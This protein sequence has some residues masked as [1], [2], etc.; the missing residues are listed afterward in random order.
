MLSSVRS[1]NLVDIVST[2]PTLFRRLHWLRA[3]QCISFKLAVMIY[4]CVRGLGSAYLADA[5]RPVARIPGRQRLRYVP[6]T[7]LSTVG[8]RAFPVAAARTRNS[9]PAEVTSS[10]SPP[11][12]KT[13]LKSHLFSASFP[14]FPKR[15]SICKVSEVHASAFFSL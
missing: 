10:N 3:P 15:C 7:R 9:F 6:S 13:K 4:Q 1:Q 8:N 5:L 14:Q 2:G 11:T 12:F